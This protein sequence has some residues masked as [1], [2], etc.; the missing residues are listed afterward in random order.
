MNFSQSQSGV[1]LLLVV[2]ILGSLLAAGLMMSEVLVRQGQIVRATSFSELAY[3]AAESGVERAFYKINQEKVDPLTLTDSDTLPNNSSYLLGLVNVITNTVPWSVSLS[4]NQSFQL[5]LDLN[6]AYPA[7]LSV[8]ASSPG[9]EVLLFSW[10]RSGEIDPLDFVTTVP[11]L[12]NYEIRSDRYHRLK[13]CNPNS[14]DVN[15]IINAPNPIPSGFEVEV[16]GFFK[17]FQRKI[18]SFFPKYF[19][20]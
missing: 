7:S 17:N 5:D 10:Q 2:L 1:S 13:I 18:K 3:Y 12:V 19:F 16:S 4:T 11:P 6:L 9:G 20:Y 8:N 15:F 14:S